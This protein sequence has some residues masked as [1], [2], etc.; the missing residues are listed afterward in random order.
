MASR[1][2]MRRS[3]RMPISTASAWSRALL[4][5]TARRL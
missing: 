1:M 2:R 3:V 4:A 5:G